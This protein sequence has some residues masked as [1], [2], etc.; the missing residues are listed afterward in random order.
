MQT[1]SISCRQREQESLEEKKPAAMKCIVYFK[2]QK[3]LR[4]K[5]APRHNE[6]RFRMVF[7]VQSHPGLAWW[8]KI[9]KCVQT[10]QQ[11]NKVD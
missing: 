11:S 3:S 10:D 2:A 9:F 8:N 1:A 5:S 7:A 6:N 4:L